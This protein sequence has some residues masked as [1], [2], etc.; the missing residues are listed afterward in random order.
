MDTP[1]PDPGEEYQ[2][3]NTQIFGIIDPPGNRGVLAEKMTAP[4][5]M[6]A[7][8]IQTPSVD[9]FV[10][11]YISAFAAEMGTQPS[12]ERYAQIMQGRHARADAC[13]LD[14]RPRVRHVRPLVRRGA[15]ADLHESVLLPRRQRLWFRR[16]RPRMR[17]SRTTTT[18]R[19]CSSGWRPRA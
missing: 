9:G 1:N 13:S 11:D 12:Y 8:P 19:R 14:D 15:V 17:A 6:P 10:A 2:H 3:V 4:F 7:D 5:N 16:Q 18:R